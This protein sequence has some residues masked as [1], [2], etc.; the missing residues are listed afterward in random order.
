MKMILSAP[1]FYRK[2]RDELRSYRLE[3]WAGGPY[4]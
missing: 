1:G 4:Q 2:K 3:D